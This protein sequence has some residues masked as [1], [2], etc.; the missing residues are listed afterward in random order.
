MLDPSTL[1]REKLRPLKRVEYDRL[2]GW[3]LFEDEPIELLHGL[4]VEMTPQGAEHSY[5]V[6]RLIRLLAPA[7]GERADLQVQQPLAVSEDSEPEPD[8][9]LVPVGLSRKEHPTRA[10][11]VVEV[12]GSTLAKDRLIKVHL[13]AAAGIPEYWVVGLKKKHVE[14]YTA[15]RS[16]K[17]TRVKRCRKGATIALQSFP[18]IQVPVAKFL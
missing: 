4:L 15:P 8:L 14:V 6:R 18:D 17:Y 12:A 1:A 11:L 16:G 10:F 7:V 3:G 5:V 9:A 2:V 13:Y